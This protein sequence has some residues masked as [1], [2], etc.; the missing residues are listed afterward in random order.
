M[1]LYATRDS[2]FC[3]GSGFSS[4]SVHTLGMLRFANA[5]PVL[6]PSNARNPSGIE[7]NAEIVAAGSV[8]NINRPNATA[9]TT[10]AAI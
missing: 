8:E 10:T 1:P 2:R 7:G 6:T 4:S 3:S 5:T 9:Y